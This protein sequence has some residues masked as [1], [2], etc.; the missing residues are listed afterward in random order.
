[1]SEGILDRERIGTNEPGYIERDVCGEVITCEAGGEYVL[2]DY[3]PEIRKI[4]HVRAAVLPSGKYVSGTKAEFAGTVA[5]TVLYADAEGKLCSVTLNADY[6]FSCPLT[7]G[8]EYTAMAD[9]MAEGTTY[10]L[11]GPR[12]ISLRTRLRSLVHLYRREC[13]TPEIRGMGSE[14]DATSLERLEESAE[15]M[16]MACGSSGEFPLT[17]T[18][19]LDTPATD[20]RAVWAGG[21]LLV[22]ECRPQAGGCLCR[23][24][25]WVRCL[26]SEGDGVPTSVRERIPFE[27]FVA[28]E[29]ADENSSFTAFGR[30]LSA[31]V[32]VIPGEGEDN[33]MLGFDVSAEIEACAMGK[34]PCNPV[35]DLYSTAYDMS[36]RYR[37]V[38]LSR[39][40]GNA[41]GNYTVSASRPR[42]ECEAEN[43][44]VI[45]DADGRIEIGNVTVEHGRAT[46]SGKLY[47]TVIFFANEGQDGAGTLLSAEIPTT[48]RVETELRP[49]GGEQLRFD[50]HGELIG[51]RA[52]IEQNAIAVDAEIA[53]A[54]R[55]AE[56]KSMRI[57]ESAEPDK[58]AAVEHEGN[59]IFVVYPKEG[60][61]LFSLAARYHKSRAAIA[62]QNDLAEDALA[63]S[64]LTHS[65]DGVHHLLISDEG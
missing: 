48:F 25:A 15:S 29:G 33:G 18:V 8:G 54:L 64:H 52:R 14:A 34:K 44:T 2:A 47:T 50:C 49:T 40:L 26:L 62:A 24:E 4:L 36:C 12:K 9:T 30:L 53:L 58:S 7:E 38:S 22:S 65:L 31:D 55:A 19:R 37:Q 42:N 41:M 6:S 27:Q 45:L 51:V 5:H 39:P 56:I 10:R 28:I 1:M 20:A 35:R 60:E 43:A 11:G 3:Q 23:G 13:I 59:R 57:L 21:N 32:T 46:V 61:T 63:T 16:T 17:A